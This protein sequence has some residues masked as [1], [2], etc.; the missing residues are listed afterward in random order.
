MTKRKFQIIGLI[1][2]LMF[3]LNACK[4]EAPN[5]YNMFNDVSVTFHNNHPFS[6]TD[7]KEVNDGD[8]V[9]IEYTITSAKQDMAAVCVK[10]E[11][12]ERPVLQINLPDDADKRSYSGVFKLQATRAGENKYRI[13][14]LN[15]QAQ[16]IGDGYKAVTFNVR[17]NFTLI[18]NRKIYLS[19]SVST[20]QPIYYSIK[21]GQAFSYA[22]GK[23][24]SADLD[25][26]FYRTP[27]AANDKNATYGHLYHLYS[28]SASPL[29][30]TEFDISSW[31]KRETLFSKAF[32]DAN[33]FRDE[34][35]SGAAIQSIASTKSPTLKATAPTSA[36]TLKL[37]SV[38]YFKT[39][40]G[41][42][43]A[44]H[45]KQ[46]DFDYTKKPFIVI[47]VKVQN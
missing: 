17:P 32:N 21:Q 18:A 6:I 7:F 2:G 25:F 47:N 40:E 38:V 41:K 23:D 26:S 37:G 20:D 4:K 3:T 33:A 30:F 14:A 15:Q 28:L 1:T 13:Y 11:G 29:P 16:Y 22:A 24:V 19:D 35:V 5:I 9:Y 43:G 42:L 27:A 45:I 36:E 8:S 12:V 31:S 46:I 39:P 34:L 44:I 10:R